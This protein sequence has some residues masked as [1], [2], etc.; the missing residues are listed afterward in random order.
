M[1]K[2]CEKIYDYKL[3]LLINEK[4]GAPRQYTSTSLALYNPCGHLK[5]VSINF[6]VQRTIFDVT[7]IFSPTFVLLMYR[8][9][10]VDHSIFDKI[11]QIEVTDYACGA[12]CVCVT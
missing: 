11:R 3:F 7:G 1:I 10:R 12:T 6:I 5:N 2:S 8:H 4:K 9:Y